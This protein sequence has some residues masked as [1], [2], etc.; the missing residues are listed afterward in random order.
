MVVAEQLPQ[1]LTDQYAGDTRITAVRADVREDSSERP[2]LFV[3]LVLSDPPEGADT[4]PVDDLWTLRRIV[5]DVMAEIEA[6]GELHGLPWFVVFESARDELL[7]W[8]DIDEQLDA[9][10]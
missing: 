2:A 8:E 9:D 1:K 6:E 7:D 3:S 4:W 5:R 10:G